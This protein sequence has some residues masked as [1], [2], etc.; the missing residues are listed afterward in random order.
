MSFLKKRGENTYN[1]SSVLN[2]QK[3]IKYDVPYNQNAC[4]KSERLI[5][6]FKRKKTILQV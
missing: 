5:Y 6:Q 1:L 4:G 2:V 3:K